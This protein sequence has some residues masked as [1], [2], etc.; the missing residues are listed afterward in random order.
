M[1]KRINEK[2]LTQYSHQL[3]EQ[4]QNSYFSTEK[5]HIHGQEILNFSPL[6]QANLLVLKNLFEQW[7]QEIS[8]LESPYFDYAQ[9]S[10]QQALKGFMNTLSQHIRIAAADFQPLMAASLQNAIKLS[11]APAQFFTQELA[12]KYSL[13]ALKEG[14][15]YIQQQRQWYKGFLDHAEQTLSEA[16]AQTP[17]ALQACFE[18]YLA[19]NPPQVS[20]EA[21]ALAP[22][23]SI[24]P[25]STAQLY[26]PEVDETADYLRYTG[27]RLLTDLDDHPDD[28]QRYF[29]DTDPDGDPVLDYLH[30][31]PLQADTAEPETAPEQL[32]AAQKDTPETTTGEPE[33]I[34]D[35]ETVPLI[36]EES[37]PEETDMTDAL[38]EEPVLA[39]LSAEE[40]QAYLEN[41]GAGLL[42]DLDDHPDDPNQY[43]PIPVEEDPALYLYELVQKFESLGEDADTLGEYFSYKGAD[44]LAD[45]PDHPDEERAYP[46]VLPLD[47]DP[48]HCCAAQASAP[49]PAEDPVEMYLDFKGAGLLTNLDDH[50]DE[51]RDYSRVDIEQDPVSQVLAMWQQQ[52]ADAPTPTTIHAT[53]NQETAQPI[54]NDQLKSETNSPSLHE[55]FQQAKLAQIRAAISLNQKFLF[56]NQLFEGDNQAFNQAIDTLD[57]LPTLEEAKKYLHQTCVEK[58]RWE[59]DDDVVQEFYELVERRFV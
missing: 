31:Y 49:K 46:E 48:I 8:K 44:L 21:A 53:I 7:Q 23:Q 13:Q 58:Y 14:F 2:N 12:Q 19:Q 55:K 41:R 52:G 54:L 1:E 34:T 50:P 38:P 57:T 20:D 4:L 29:A 30:T 33:D 27:A 59:I 26:A 47:K 40:I 10:V 32:I 39:T 43:A 3:A 42:T 24:L 51:L 56:I 45:Y 9:E 11:I 28:D 16:D 25:L 5:T 17:T 6:K 22:F 36:G 18:Q 37:S 35:Q 15:K